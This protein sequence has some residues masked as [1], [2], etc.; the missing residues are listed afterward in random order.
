MLLGAVTVAAAQE[1]CDSVTI[2]FRQSKIALDSA[3]MGN[4]EVLADIRER[5]E[6][7]SQH[8][9]PYRLQSVAVVGAAS[10]EGSIKFNN[11]LSERRAQK[12]FDYIGALTPLESGTTSF[13]FLGRDWT[14]LLTA[15]VADPN[16][17]FR[18]EVIAFLEPIV[19]NGDKPQDRNL[20]KF[21][22]LR[23]GVPYLYVYHRIF[24][25]LRKSTILLR[26]AA[27]EI[28]QSLR[29]TSESLQIEHDTVTMV[30]H[31]TVYVERVVYYCPPC[32]PFYM[33]VRTNLLY[34]ALAV[35]NLG[36]EFYLGKNWSLL[37]NWGYAWWGKDGSNRLWRTYGGDV[38]LRWW[39]GRRAHQKP[40]SGHHLG[41]FAGI[42]T[43]DFCFGKRGYMG[44]L[45][46]GTL[47][48]RY[49]VNAGVEYGYSLPMARRLNIDFTLG[50]GYLGGEIRKYT[51]DGGHYVWKSTSRQHWIGPTNLEISLC[52]LIGCKNFNS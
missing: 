46:K 19:T 36:I 9:P 23:G 51:F 45:H 27:Q 7:N 30:V 1:H 10:P 29:E 18:D 52:W 43:Y 47:W 26:Y 34:D 44:G 42:L 12:I 5:I 16:V 15:V 21:K 41:L 28:P 14:G 20:E 17:P 50:I 25:E 35:P 2:H 24:P 4:A 37:A 11:W 8:H 39:F 6:Q 38:A 33:D 31:D 3:Y 48:D 32:K 49:H 22:K 13:E 40:L